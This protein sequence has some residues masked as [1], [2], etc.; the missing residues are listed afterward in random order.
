MVVEGAVVLEIS[1]EGAA[2]S[3]SLKPGYVLF[4]H[5]VLPPGHLLTSPTTSTWLF[6]KHEPTCPTPN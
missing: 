1:C 5:G 6:P 2:P 4:A 3:V